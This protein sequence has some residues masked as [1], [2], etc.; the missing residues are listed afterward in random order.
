METDVRPRT[1]VLPQPPI[2]RQLNHNNTNATTS[3]ALT[4]TT[5]T[6]VSL[7]TLI[8]SEPHLLSQHIEDAHK[9]ADM[10]CNVS[11]V[12]KVALRPKDGEDLPEL[13]EGFRKLSK[14]DPLVVWTAEESREDV[15]AGGGEHSGGDPPEGFARRV[16]AVQ[17]QSM[18]G[19]DPRT[20][21]H[22]ARQ[23]FEYRGTRAS[24]FRQSV[25]DHDH[26]LWPTG[27]FS[28]S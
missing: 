8:W 1:S 4:S 16:R 15:I 3:N 22:R 11:P 17:S 10:K 28:D 24:F 6:R 14:S 9:I 20:L 23:R 19:N 13:V 12:V 18:R 25:R 5:T 7:V 21:A 27:H 2:Y 26:S